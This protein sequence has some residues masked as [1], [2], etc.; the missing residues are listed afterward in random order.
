MRARKKLNGEDL[1]PEEWRDIP[2][3]DGLY[4]VSSYGRIRAVKLLNPYMNRCGG[5]QNHRQLRVSLTQGNGKRVTRSVLR[6]VAE[7]FLGIPDGMNPTHRNGFL[8][9]CSVRNIVFLSKEDI[10]KRY[11]GRGTRRPVVKINAAGEVIDH[12]TSAKAAARANYL[13]YGQMLE[14]CKGRVK[15]E[16]ADGY[17][18]RWDD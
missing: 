4:Q 8:S 6:L 15:S 5:S 11:G 3:F 14:R 7:A 2:G 16:F 1:A 13:C 10:G 17:S 18:Y 12:Y 9:D